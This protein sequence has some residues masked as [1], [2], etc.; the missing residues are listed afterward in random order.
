MN[1]VPGKRRHF[2]ATAAG[3]ILLLF[4]GC[5]PTQG[6]QAAF[7]GVPRTG[8]VPLLVQFNDLS[9]PGNAP[10]HTWTWDFGDG[11]TSVLQNPAHLYQTPGNYPVTL[12]ISTAHGISSHHETEYILANEPEPE[13][14]GEGEG[15]GETEKLVSLIDT[16]GNLK[17][18]GYLLVDGISYDLLEKKDIAAGEGEGEGEGENTILYNH[19]QSKT[20]NATDLYFE[21]NY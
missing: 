15:E 7:T 18:R 8:D 19:V 17:M 3:M 10:I 20:G 4:S 16:N 9:A 5:C 14:E 21:T 13:G 2:H 1:T 11:E 6:P 12:T